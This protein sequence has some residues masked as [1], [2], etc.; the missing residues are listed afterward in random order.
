MKE[1]PLLQQNYMFAKMQG[2]VCDPGQYSGTYVFI[3]SLS[4]LYKTIVD[5]DV[6]A[7]GSL[8][9]VSTLVKKVTPTWRLYGRHPLSGPMI[10]FRT[11]CPCKAHQCV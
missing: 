8:G 2:S 10:C 5:K 7:Y 3:C 6:V 4:E 9:I 11:R 1:R